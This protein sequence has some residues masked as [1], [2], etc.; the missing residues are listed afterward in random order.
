[1]K[2]FS[3]LNPPSPPHAPEVGKVAG[4]SPDLLLNL[5]IGHSLFAW[6]SLI[7]VSYMINKQEVMLSLFNAAA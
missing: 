2:V 4:K 5:Q 1:M 7:L 3:P 6:Q